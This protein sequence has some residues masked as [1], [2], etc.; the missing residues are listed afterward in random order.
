MIL[1]APKMKSI[2]QLV[3]VNLFA[4]LRPANPAKFKKPIMI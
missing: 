1:G 2:K 4:L 3:P